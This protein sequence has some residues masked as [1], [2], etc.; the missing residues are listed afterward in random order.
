MHRHH[1]VKFHSTDINTD[2]ITDTDAVTNTDTIYIYIYDIQIHM[3]Y[4]EFWV[5]PPPRC[6]MA[7]RADALAGGMAHPTMI[8][9]NSWAVLTVSLQYWSK[10]LPQSRC[11]IFYSR[12]CPRGK[13]QFLLPVGMMQHSACA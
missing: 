13:R 1:G 12:Q 10:I 5:A 3:W 7:E 8:C 11:K 6:Q 9:F 2:T 4:V